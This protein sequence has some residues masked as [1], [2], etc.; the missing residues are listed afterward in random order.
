MKTE[1]QV[2][3]LHALVWPLLQR[4]EAFRRELTLAADALEELAK[5]YPDLKVFLEAIAGNHRE[6]LAKNTEDSL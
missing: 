2:R 3:E 1:R 5:K 4:I 6:V